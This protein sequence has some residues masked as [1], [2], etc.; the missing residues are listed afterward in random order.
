MQASTFEPI[1]WQFMGIG[2]LTSLPFL[3]KLDDMSGR[4]L[5]NADSFSPPR[6][7]SCDISRSATTRSLPG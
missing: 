7:T 4:Y 5:D 6:T 2:R 1:F 3:V